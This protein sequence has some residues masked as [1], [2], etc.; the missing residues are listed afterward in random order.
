MISEKK[1]LFLVKQGFKEEN[2]DKLSSLNVDKHILWFLSVEKK[3]FILHEK[4]VLL[5]NNYFENSLNVKT[6]K[7]SFQEILEEA[8]KFEKNQKRLL[9]NILYTFDNGFYISVLN[10]SDLREEGIIMSNCVGG[11]EQRVF[12]GEVGIL[13]LKNPSK[14]TIAH[15]EIRKNGFIGQNYAKA[16]TH[17]NK[18]NWMMIVEFFEKNSKNVD[19][20]KLFGE[21]YVSTC[22][23]SNIEEIILS[24]PTSVRM[25]LENGEKKNE[26]ITGFEVKRFLPYS[27]AKN[28][29]VKL[30]SKEDMVKWLEK[31]KEEV[32]NA[33]NDIIYQVLNTSAS[34]MYLSDEMKEKIFGKKNG[35]YLMK[36]DNYDLSELTPYTIM[37]GDDVEAGEMPMVEMPEQELPVEIAPEVRDEPQR[38]DREIIPGLRMPVILRNLRAQAVAE[39]EV[40]A[41]RIYENE[42]PEEGQN[43]R[44]DYIEVPYEGGYGEDRLVEAIYAGETNEEQNGNLQM[45]PEPFEDIIRRAN[46]E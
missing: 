3:G 21:S 43:P 7:K 4:D 17:L 13:A 40:L 46:L 34:K 16:N 33:Y 12:E 2:I 26:Q 41:E 30:S 29:A 18:E 15:I 31:K 28:S 27:N 23:G 8:R 45:P 38:E 39:N 37:E 36:G 22:Y 32:V 14:K 1:K 25:Y 5:I 35:S 19:L 10:A 11:Y 44:L 9:K 6:E 42:A 24:I 20:S